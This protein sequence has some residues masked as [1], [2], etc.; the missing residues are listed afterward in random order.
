M[1]P[2]TWKENLEITQRCIYSRRRPRTPTW[3]IWWKDR[4]LHQPC[5]GSSWETVQAWPPHR[6]SGFQIKALWENQ[7][8]WN[9]EIIAMLWENANWSP[10]SM[11]AGMKVCL[12][13][14]KS[15]LSSFVRLCCTKQSV[16]LDK[17][18]PSILHERRPS[19]DSNRC[20]KWFI[21]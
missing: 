2:Q 15:E 16:P 9:R 11:G 17:W 13:K 1:L 18:C 20:E 14:D 8:R 3:G 4:H 21:I 6:N 19:V 12:C 7:D 5:S 10:L